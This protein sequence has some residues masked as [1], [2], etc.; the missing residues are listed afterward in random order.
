MK[1]KLM[2]MD[3]DGTLLNSSSRVSKRTYE[4]LKKA[5]DKGVKIVLATG[6]LYKSAIYYAENLGLKNAIITSNGAL[7]HDID[8]NIIYENN[9]SDSSALEIMETIEKYNLYYH[10]YTTDSV[11][12]KTIN[13][14]ILSRYYADFE[15]N[16]I[17]GT[18]KFKEFQDILGNGNKFNK[19][20]VADNTDT[21]EKLRALEKDLLRIKGIE[22]TSSWVNNLEM[23]NKNVSKKT[24]VMYLCESLN[25]NPEEVITIGDNENDIP[26]IEYAG[27]G[28]AMNN[29]LDIV[30]ERADYITD[31][32]DNDGVAKAIEKFI[33][34][35]E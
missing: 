25:I 30:K 20:L 14:E 35:D 22:V 10:L 18:N 28:I 27:L 29:G 1:Y 12:S 17:I 21:R 9:L 6:R 31:T 4:A 15:G 16:L 33:L 13:K 23:M 3:M 11:Y 34:G 32:N 5:E 7:I 8:G 26:M 19:I 2:A 24:A